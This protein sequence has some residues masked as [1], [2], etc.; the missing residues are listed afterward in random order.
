MK[1]IKTENEK[2]DFIIPWVDG[3]DPLWRAEME[4]YVPEEMRKKKDVAGDERY[5][6][7]GLLRYLFRGIE[8]FAPWVNKVYFVTWG[9]LPK[10]LDTNNPKL[11]IVKHE[12]F[13]PSKYLP[14]F[15][16]IPIALNLHR[17]KGLSE[18]FVLFNDD[19]YLTSFCKKEVFFKKGLPC[20]MAV[21]DAI[22]AREIQSYYSM[23]FNAV[24]LLNIRFNKKK[25]IRK[26]FF[27][28]INLKYGKLVVKN[29]CLLPFSLF[30]GF[31]GVHVP[32]G[33]LKASFEEMWKDYHDVLDK[34]SSHKFRDVTDITEE[35]AEYY[36]FAEGKFCPVNKLKFG[37]NI[38][39][40]Q[41]SAASVLESG[42]YKYVCLND[43][44]DTPKYH[45]QFV[46]IKNAFDK[47]LPEKSS[48]ESF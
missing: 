34:S 36:Q 1:K 6:D 10:W 21:T 16:F 7:N 15:N 41:W 32:N 37:R 30:T 2:I 28:W 39:I 27:K 24:T 47:I 40:K 19:M 11:V 35:L 25:A 33:Y 31:Y 5:E 13:I 26:H 23:L 18:R 4:K 20:D 14:T 9:H 8:K 46:K 22:P 12:D 29:I 3:S 38:S 17:I 48:Y 42:K 45:D 44:S 43:V